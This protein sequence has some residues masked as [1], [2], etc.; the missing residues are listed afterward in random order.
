MTIDK[1]FTQHPV[2]L[3]RAFTF[4]FACR[5][6]EYPLDLY[7]INYSVYIICIVL[8]LQNEVHFCQ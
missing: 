7:P 8:V 4:L 5:P 6:V 2:Q 1:L 3:Y